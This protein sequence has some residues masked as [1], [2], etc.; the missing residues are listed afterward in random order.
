[1]LE[2][3]LGG[4]LLLLLLEIGKLGQDFLTRAAHGDLPVLNQHDIIDDGKDVG[5]VRDQ[6]NRG[7]QLLEVEHGLQQTGFALFVKVGIGLVEHDYPGIAVQRT[8]E[9]DA[10]ALTSGKH[11]PLI[12]DL[13]VVALGQREDHVVD[14]RELGGENDPFGIHGAQ[15]CDVFSDATGEQFH[16]LREIPDERSEFFGIPSGDVGAINANLAARG[17]PYAE[18]QLA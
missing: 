15:T 13:R 4:L 18:Q 9:A 17:A 5:L 3:S 2:A 10:L 8:G 7:L 11:G 1:M 14:A 16:V 12:P 6:D